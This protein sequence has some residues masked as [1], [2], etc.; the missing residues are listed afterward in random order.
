MHA[1]LAYYRLASSL[2][3][4][5]HGYLLSEC[6]YPAAGAKGTADGRQPRSGWRQMVQPP[7]L[8][9]MRLAIS[10]LLFSARFWW[11]TKSTIVPMKRKPTVIK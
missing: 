4:F 6:Q 10:A 9:A 11:R 2:L 7:M 1:R 3:F 8:L 5:A